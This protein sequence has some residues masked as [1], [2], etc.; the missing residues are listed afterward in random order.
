[1]IINSEY[2]TGT[3]NITRINDKL[4][5]SF[6]K[7]LSQKSESVASI[8][9]VSKDRKIVAHLLFIE[10]RRK[11]EYYDYSICF[12]NT[13]IYFMYNFL[14]LI[15]NTFTLS[16]SFSDLS[17][18][19]VT[20]ELCERRKQL[21]NVTQFAQYFSLLSTPAFTKENYSFTVIHG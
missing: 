1:M 15:Y 17:I 8:V 13:L 4:T 9:F 14:D 20:D 10:N 11:L 6:L 16:F 5:G 2:Y 18:E 3:V 21:K 12:I 7:T 19:S